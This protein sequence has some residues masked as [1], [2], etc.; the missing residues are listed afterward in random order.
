MKE[1]PQQGMLIRKK[2]SNLSNREEIKY[3][4]S[5]VQNEIALPDDVLVCE[6]FKSYKMLEFT[7]ALL[8]MICKE[9][10]LIIAIF[11]AICYYEVKVGFPLYPEKYTETGVKNG[12]FATLII[13]NIVN[14]LFCKHIIT[15]SD[16]HNIKICDIF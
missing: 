9:N 11:S 8:T 10:Y 15:Q 1:S 12:L 16:R 2:S 5:I 13:L 14:F 3:I 7:S 6:L 4:D